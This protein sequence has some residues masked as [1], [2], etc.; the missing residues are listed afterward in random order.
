MI[1]HDTSQLFLYELPSVDPINYKRSFA[2]VEPIRVALLWS[3]IKG[4]IDTNI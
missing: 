1:I 4:G 3:D 2:D